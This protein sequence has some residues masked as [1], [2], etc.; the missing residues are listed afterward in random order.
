MSEATSTI[1]AT[2]VIESIR[3]RP[4][5]YM[6]VKSLTAFHQFL[7]GYQLA[8][9]LHQIKDDRLGLRIPS[10]FHDWVAYR[11][12]FRES[13]TGWCNM[14]VATSKSEEEAFDRFFILLEEHADRVPRVVAEI[15]G[16]SSSTNSGLVP[17]PERVRLV[18]FTNDP[19][20]FVLYGSENWRDRFYPHLSWMHGLY[21]GEWVIHDEA[22]YDKMIRENQEWEREL[23]ERLHMRSAKPA[24]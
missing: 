21:G 12:H 8:C 17:P 23:E 19:G 4:A 9:D 5:M 24:G 22:S 7:N 6:G 2:S 1:D 16:P 15:I 11:T 10:D 3:R 14:I 13:T 18:K 20:F